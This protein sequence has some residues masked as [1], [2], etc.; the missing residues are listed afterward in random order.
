MGLILC[1]V[2][3]P[4]N[5]EDIKRHV[6]DPWVGKIPWRKALATHP[7]FLPGES[8]GQTSL[9]GYSPHSGK[10]LNMT[11]A[12]QHTQ[13]YREQKIIYITTDYFGHRAKTLVSSDQKMT[14]LLIMFLNKLSILEV[15][16]FSLLKSGNMIAWQTLMDNGH[17]K[18]AEY[19][20]I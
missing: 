2:N 12:P 5:A 6:F 7:V 3:W 15:F 1:T 17:R 19:Y 11:E 16:V 8:S 9:V 4:S 20:S 10:E 13:M 18:N 14:C